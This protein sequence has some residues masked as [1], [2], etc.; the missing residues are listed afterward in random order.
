MFLPCDITMLNSELPPFTYCTL[1]SI[2]IVVVK[3]YSYLASQKLMQG[4][5]VISLCLVQFQLI[6]RETSRFCLCWRYLLFR[7]VMLFKHHVQCNEL[8][9]YAYVLRFMLYV[10]SNSLLLRSFVFSAFVLYSGL[11][12]GVWCQVWHSQTSLFLEMRDFI[13]TLL[14]FFTGEFSCCIFNFFYLVLDAYLSLRTLLYKVLSCC[15][16]LFGLIHWLN[17]GFFYSI[18]DG[19]LL[20]VYLLWLPTACCGINFIGKKFI[21]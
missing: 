1:I 21:T 3:V 6:C 14:A 7:K 17:F 15:Y 12:R 19:K 13:V 8:V 18:G 10:I 9:C 2:F 11:K 20:K 16:F 4:M 5:S